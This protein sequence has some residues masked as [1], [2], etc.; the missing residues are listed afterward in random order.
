M[1]WNCFLSIFPS[2]IS[3]FLSLIATILICV[4]HAASAHAGAWQQNVSIGGFN[5]VHIYTPD[6]SSPVGTGKSL[7]IV[8]HGCVQPIDNFLTAKLEDAAEA[9]GMV[10]AV[11]DAMNKAG[12]SCWSYWQGAVSRTAGDYKHLINLANLMSADA[13]RAIDAKQIYLTGLSSGAAMAAQTACLAPDVFAGVASSAG[14]TIGTSSSGA[15]STCETVSSA[16]FKARCEGYAG[17]NKGDLASQVAVIGHGSADTTV[18]TCYNQQNADGFAAVY[19]VT[20]QAG[21]TTITDAVG[22]TASE[23]T[24]AN[25]R[26]AMLWF[27]GLDHSWSGGVGASGSYVA[28]DSINFASYLGAHF[29]SSNQRVDRNSGPVISQHEVLEQNNSLV[30][31]GNA[32][33]EEGSVSNVSV[34]ISALDTGAPV[35]IELLNTSAAPSD[36]FYSV[37]S[38]TLEDGLYKAEAV[39]TDNEGKDGEVAVATGRVGPEP[40]ATA[41]V[42]SN[43]NAVVNAQCATITGTAIDANQNLS[44]VVVGFANGSVAAVLEGNSFTAEQCG[45]A[46]GINTATVTASDTTSLSSTDTVSF[47]IDAGSSG[48]YNFHI[49]EGHITWGSGYSACYLAFG[50]A[51]FVMREVGVANDLCEW[52]AD[53]EPTCRGPAQTCS[54]DS[55]TPVDT[56]SDGIE[57]SADNCPNIANADQA[58]NDNDGLGNVCDSTP[59]GE[60]GNCTETTASNYA[61]VQAGR[62]TSSGFYTY[63]VGSGTNMGLY[64]VFTVR[65]LAETST[66]YYDLGSCP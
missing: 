9:H 15:I 45:L 10:I 62:A 4:L 39:A 19:E 14:P 12:F 66:G 63:A 30:V 27:N 60:P 56:D 28:D 64:N 61:H 32:V 59:N 44:S 33:D 1:F 50:V 29:A 25:K 7:L 23:H 40:P 18:N 38:R 24:W 52:V 41:P 20:Q 8:L 17:S 54:T 46:G 36:G 37:T 43:L 11:P 55:G 58:D 51:T 48:D 6:S 53:D 34:T 26:V 65:T 13:S 35:L 2:F 5:K 16:T 49:G 31:S 22:H 3:S 47:T 42:L 21:S 57:D